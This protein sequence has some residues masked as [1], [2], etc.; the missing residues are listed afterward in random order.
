MNTQRQHD[1]FNSFLTDHSGE[2]HTVEIHQSITI[3]NN[4]NSNSAFIWVP[5]LQ[6]CKMRESQNQKHGVFEEMYFL[7]IVA[8]VVPK[9]GDSRSKYGKTEFQT[10]ISIFRFKQFHVYTI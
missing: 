10:I 4:S 3:H 5:S 9:V 8:K 2:A 1:M 6:I 7:V